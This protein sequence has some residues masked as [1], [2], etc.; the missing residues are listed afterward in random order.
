MTVQILCL[1][2]VLDNTTTAAQTSCKKVPDTFD[3]GLQITMFNSL[4]YLLLPTY[5]SRSKLGVL[6]MKKNRSCLTNFK[7]LMT[8]YNAVLNSS[9]EL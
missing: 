9:L 4:S 7:V 6:S 2:V 8:L 3:T 1:V 5:L